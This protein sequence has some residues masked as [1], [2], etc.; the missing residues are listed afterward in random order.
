MVAPLGTALTEQQAGL[1]YG[2]DQVIIATDADTAGRTA[3][4]RDYWQLAAWGIDPGRARLPEGSDPASILTSLGPT[5]LERILDKATPAANQ[6][7]TELITGL[8]PDETVDHATRILAASPPSSW[9]R[10]STQIAQTLGVE[11][12][13][14]RATL[15]RHVE[16]WNEDPRRAAHQSVLQDTE[17]RHRLRT[18]EHGKQSTP[19]T[20]RVA[21]TAVD[22]AGRIGR[23]EERPVDT[24]PSPNPS[25]RG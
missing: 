25:H 21:P 15:A 10:T 4:Y 17:I 3:A 7:I 12:D 20:G 16:G 22:Q 5:A 23:P 1:L 24:S 19:I 6:I 18:T 11:I 8:P 9:E 14:V 13:I 2:H